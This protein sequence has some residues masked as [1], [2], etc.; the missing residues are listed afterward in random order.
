MTFKPKM[1]LNGM[2]VAQIEAAWPKDNITDAIVKY[3]TE[4][5]GCP[6]LINNII[7]HIRTATSV[8]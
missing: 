5:A 7:R 4:N 1:W 2:F 6:L 3:V 8:V